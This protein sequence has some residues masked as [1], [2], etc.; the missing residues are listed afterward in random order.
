MVGWA[1]NG[2][3]GLEVLQY[4]FLRYCFRWSCCSFVQLLL[5]FQL[6][7]YWLIIALAQFCYVLLYFVS[8]YY[9]TSGMI[10]QYNIL[11]TI[12]QVDIAFHLL[13]VL[14]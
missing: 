4:L 12:K 5:S 2:N 7:A 13:E 1:V 8:D 6:L 10:M 11:F 14:F 3:C 9:K